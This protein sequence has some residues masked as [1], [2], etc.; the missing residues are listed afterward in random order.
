VPSP[1]RRRLNYPEKLLIWLALTVSAG[2]E[3]MLLVGV[4]HHEWIPACP[5]I[6]FWWS[7]LIAFLARTSLTR[8]DMKEMS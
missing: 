4:V 5:T 3:F 2:W 1:T 8:I 6:G 7:V